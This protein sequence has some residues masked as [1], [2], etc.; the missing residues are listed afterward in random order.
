MKWQEVHNNKAHSIG[1]YRAAKELLFGMHRQLSQAN[2]H[3]P[4]D[5]NQQLMLLH[6]YLNVKVAFD[7][8]S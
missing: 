7:L 6:S 8:I 1:N 2:I 4:A 3:I 5:L